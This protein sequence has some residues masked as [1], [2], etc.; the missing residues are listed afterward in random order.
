MR[1]RTTVITVEDCE[2]KHL[3]TI[4][5][6][7]RASR[8]WGQTAIYEGRR[9]DVLTRQGPVVSSVIPDNTEHYIVLDR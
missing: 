6:V 4:Q 8:E 1:N 9:W 7:L 2:G 3:E 5:R